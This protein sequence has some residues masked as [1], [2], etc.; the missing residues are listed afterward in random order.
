MTYSIN[1]EDIWVSRVPLP[2]RHT[3]DRPV[4][5]TFDHV[6]PGGIIPDWNIYRPRWAEVG[7]ADVPSTREQEPAPGGPGSPRL[8]TRRPGVPQATAAV[9]VSFR[10]HAQQADHGRLEIDL[11]GR[12]GR[13][14]SRYGS[15]RMAGCV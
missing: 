11:L 9:D 13:G 5:D 10:L 1:K 2:L 4:A 14:R 3:V 8:R 7:V 15:T 12:A 6:P